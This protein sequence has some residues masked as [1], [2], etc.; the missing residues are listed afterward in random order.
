MIKLTQIYVDPEKLRSF[1]RELKSFTEACDN[2]ANALNSKINRL[3][4]TWRD[5]EYQNFVSHFL[6][7]KELL[8]KFV[9]ESRRIEPLLEKDAAAIEEYLRHQL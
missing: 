3:G 1:A 4:T 9:E 6:P 2:Y 5:Q 8:K 7:T